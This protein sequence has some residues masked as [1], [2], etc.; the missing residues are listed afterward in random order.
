M[1]K[2][3]KDEEFLKDIEKKLRKK[4]TDRNSEKMPLPPPNK[5]GP[6]QA[7]NR[8]SYF[9]ILV[10][11]VFTF[12]A[13]NRNDGKSDLT[14]VS[15][16]QFI[17]DVTNNAISEVLIV[18]NLSII[19]FEKDGVGYKTRIPYT[20]INL[21][22]KL[23]VGNVVIHSETREQSKFLL[24][25]LQWL[26]WIVLMLFFWFIISRQLRGRGSEAFNFG[27]SKAQMIDSNDIKE[28]FD[29]V[30]GCQEAI[31][32]LKDVVEFLRN[33][34]SFGSLGAQIPKG[35]LLVGMPGTGKTLLAKAVAGEANVPFFSI[36]GSDFVEMFVGVG[37]SRVRSLF[38]NGKKNSPCIIFVDEIDAVGRARGAGYGGGH[39]EREQTLNQLLVEMDGFATE[40]G[41]ILI[42][43][44]N[45]PDV[46]D[47]ALLR[48][49]R[50]DRQVVV[51]VPD[52][53]GREAILK[54]HAKKIKLKEDVDLKRIARAT[55]GM[56]GADL[57]NVINESALIAAKNRRRDVDADCLDKAKDKVLLGSERRSIFV[58]S[59][60]KQNTAY[61]EAGHALVSLLMPEANDLDKVT[62]IPRGRALGITHFLPQDGKFTM[63]QKSL[64]AELRVLYGGRVAEEIIF[65]DVTNGAMNDIE[66]ATKIAKSM[67]CEW[68]LSRLGPIAF[69]E[70]KTPLYLPTNEYGSPAAV[71]SE[72]ITKKIDLEIKRILDNAYSET[73]KILKKH[74]KD[75]HKLA[76]L[77]L[78][79]ETVG[80]DEIRELLNFEAT[81]IDQK[82]SRHK[83]KN[84]SK[85]LG[86]VKSGDVALNP[87]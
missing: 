65:K 74:I 64:E 76:K 79:K 8:F 59:R 24:V 36:S 11:I 29:D 80:M 37:A 2:K 17:N 56:T 61:H 82:R 40:Q 27:K 34:R 35:V 22:E 47:K 75:L 13:L 69:S 57:A 16:S 19:E 87:A 43:A 18:E 62:I 15:Y 30:K 48:P 38:E 7:W 66:R 45:R 55:V 12:I 60:E 81:K 68:G 5:K 10:L 46:L 6:A 72:E 14:Q 44:T 86:E 32:D 54:V 73:K 23:L 42:A 85:K 26:P 20:D 31:E 21:V 9:L 41:I 77:L 1:N 67:V 39:D 25:L 58:S 78:E 4:S 49:G 50:F 53:V 51:E 52:L 33:P 3:D 63:N 84:K 71:H 70:K 28:R 83:N